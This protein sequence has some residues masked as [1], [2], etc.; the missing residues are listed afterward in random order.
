MIFLHERTG[1]TTSK[2]H[3]T[4]IVSQNAFPTSLNQ[5]FQEW[6]LRDNNGLAFC[7]KYTGCFGRAKRWV[8]SE[9]EVGSALLGQLELLISGLPGTIKLILLARLALLDHLDRVTQLYGRIRHYIWVV[10]YAETALNVMWFAFLQHLC[11]RIRF[12]LRVSQRTLRIFF[13]AGQLSALFR[14]IIGL[15]ADRQKNGFCSPRY[16]NFLSWKRLVAELTQV[17]VDY[18]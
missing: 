16:F 2:L 18:C 15:L 6:L 10:D 7:L 8:E 12:W 14:I 17:E 3:D 9:F 13:S 1:N 5:F 11:L 4:R